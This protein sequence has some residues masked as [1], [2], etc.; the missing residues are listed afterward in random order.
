[1][2]CVK[3]PQ[4]MRGYWEKPEETAIAIRNG[5]FHTGDIAVMDPGGYFRIVDR[6]KDMII[7]SGFNVFPNE[8]EGVLALHPGVLEC[9]VIGVPDER[10]GEA[11]KAFVVRKDP[12]LTEA[13]LM[14]YCREHLAG[15]KK[16]KTIEF[17]DD[18]PRSNIGKI[19]RRALRD[20]PGTAAARSG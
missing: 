7:V 18:L 4:V 16:P 5:W 17:R 11:V 2:L 14:E 12:A 10:A 6:L 3:G 20:S 19:L 1:E 13:D 9:A 8:I 15:Y